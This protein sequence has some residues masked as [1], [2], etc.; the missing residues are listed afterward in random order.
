M[1]NARSFKQ[2]LDAAPTA[3]DDAVPFKQNLDPAPGLLESHHESTAGDDVPN[4]RPFKQEL[5]AVVDVEGQKSLK[6]APHKHNAGENIVTFKQNLDP[7]PGLLESYSASAK[8]DD[9]S[10]V[11]HAR[12]EGD[13]EDTIDNPFI[14]HARMEG[15]ATDLEL[16]GR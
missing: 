14:G 11:G 8:R 6:Q 5:D 15:D 2:N 3:R 7:A 1:P 12:I 13:D 9:V 4:V 16:S 10:H